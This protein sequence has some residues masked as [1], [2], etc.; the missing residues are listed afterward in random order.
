MKAK[1]CNFLRTGLKI[2]VLFALMLLP[3]PAFSLSEV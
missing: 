2:V 3:L 1:L